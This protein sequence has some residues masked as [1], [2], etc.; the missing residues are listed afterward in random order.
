MLNMAEIFTMGEMIVE[1]MRTE[2]GC[3]LKNAGLFRGP[4]PSGAPAIFLDTAARL[5]HHAAMIGCVGDD[6]FGLCLRERL[7][8]DGADMSHVTVGNQPTGCAFVTYFEDGSRKFI[9][10]IGN[11]AAVE[12][13]VPAPEAFAGAK[14]FHIMGCS[15]MADPAF[16][17]A[18][19]KAMHLAREAGA[20]I[21][22]DPNIRPELM[23]DE[24]A[25]VLIDEVLENTQI[26]LPGVGELLSLTGC[27]DTKSAVQACLAKP[28]MRIVAVKNGSAGCSVYDK[29]GRLDVGIYPIEPLD[30]TGAGD[31]FD[32]A[33][34]CSLLEGF[35]IRE[36][37]LRASAAAAMNTAAFGPMEGD[38]SADKLRRFMEEREAPVCTYQALR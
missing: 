25:R 12:A 31:C 26:F 37:A 11:S 28:A 2:V 32:A 13:P 7:E 20:V 16:G 17:R 27:S 29:D 3:E 4:Y 22:F 36:A 9:F 35:P 18:I 38:I 14:L 33:F 1:I 34:V 6:D 24:S 19:V 10:H 8:R 30:A 15:L 23:R 5:G 21:S